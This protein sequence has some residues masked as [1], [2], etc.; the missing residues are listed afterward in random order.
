MSTLQDRY[1]NALSTSSV[2]ARD[3]YVEGVDSL[4]AATP[5]MDTAF[6]DAVTADDGFALGHIALARSKQLMGRGHEAK[7]PLARARELAAATTLREQSQIAV[8]YRIL[9]GQ[10][11]AALAA[12]HEHMKS[13]PRDAMA[14]AP[15]T[16]VFGLIGFS[17]KVGREI[18]QLAILAP[19]EKH[20]GNDWWYRTQLAFAQ[21]ELQRH[22]EGLR[23]IEIALEGFPRSAHAAHIRAHLFYELGDREAGL[24]YLA[25]W[26]KDYARE[27]LLHCHISW[28]V[29]L[30]SLETGRRKDAWRV[31]DEALRPGAAWGPQINVLTDCAAFLARAEVAGEPRRPEPW[32]ELGTYAARWFPNSGINFA[33][34]HS[35]LAFAM[36]GDGASLQKIIDQPKGPAADMMAPLARGF[37]AFARGDWS[38]AVDEIEPLLATHERLGGSRAQR[39]LLEYLV[40]SAM[41]R[42]GR[43]EEARRQISTRRPQNGK[44][45]FPVAGL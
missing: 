34:F 40:T 17:G 41:L 36:S 4:M 33:D 8:F 22:D 27:G 6:Q 7:A 45:G 2:A 9:T 35:A 32:Q 31:Y 16:S 23:N 26:T 14:L 42:A 15:A 19:L 5:G 12:I 29:A 37:D 39:D 13:W 18:D 1:G 10:A 24:A 30:W 3:A 43:P 25:D 28:H 20:Y 21:I 38:V 44:S 11:A